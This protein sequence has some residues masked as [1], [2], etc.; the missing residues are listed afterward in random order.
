MPTHDYAGLQSLSRRARLLAPASS[1]AG[2]ASALN[3]KADD[4][5]AMDAAVDELG[6]FRATFARPQP[7]AAEADEH[8]RRAEPPFETKAVAELS[9]DALPAG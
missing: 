9:A 4:A 2:A 6:G 8:R 7:P 5:P 3:I 1:R